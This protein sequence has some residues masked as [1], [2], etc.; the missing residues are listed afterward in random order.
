MRWSFTGL[1]PFLAG[2]APAGPCGARSCDELGLLYCYK[3]GVSINQALKTELTLI[4]YAAV[5]VGQT[6]AIEAGTLLCSL[7]PLFWL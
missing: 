4:T 5:G 3:F 1:P 2:L 6:P 7:L